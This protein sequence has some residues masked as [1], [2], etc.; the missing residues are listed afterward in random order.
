MK[1]GKSVLIL[2]RYVRLIYSH[3]RMYRLCWDLLCIL[4]LEKWAVGTVHVAYLKKHE[5][6]VMFH[7]L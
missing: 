2:L 1:I 3:R 5:E 4:F 6:W 7:S